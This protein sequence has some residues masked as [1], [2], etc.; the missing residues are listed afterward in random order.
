M[1]DFPDPTRIDLSTGIALSVHQ[2][3]PDDG[4]P[5]VL[6]HGFPELAYSW[7]HQVR[8]LSEAGFYAIA[9]DMRG[10]G[11]SDSPEGIASFDLEHLTSDLAGLLDALEIERA[12]FAGHDWGGFVAW[13]MPIAYPERTAGVIGVNTPYVPFPDTEPPQS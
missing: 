2:A 10:Y 12:V 11:A 4:V 3:G 8:A 1:K 9:P 5:V 6:C 13:G 7:R